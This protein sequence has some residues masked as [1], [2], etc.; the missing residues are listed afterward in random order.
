MK[1]ENSKTTKLHVLILNQTDKIH[2]RRGGKSIALS[3]TSIYY[4]WKSILKNHT[5][6]INLKYQLKTG[7]YLELLTPE[8]TE[9]K[10]TKDKNVE[11]ISHL[12]ITQV[13]LVHWNIVKNNY[14][15]DSRVFYAFVP[16]K[17]FTSLLEIPPTN[18]I[19]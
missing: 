10:I 17:P 18:Y 7:Y 15:Q 19:F 14:Q 6:T 4:T 12:E 13:V 5:T 1:S 2:L 16:N 8:S 3:K 11:N 9:N